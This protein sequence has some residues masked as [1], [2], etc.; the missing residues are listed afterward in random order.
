MNRSKTGEGILRREFRMEQAEFMG[1]GQG[2]KQLVRVM[3]VLLLLGVSFSSA[4]A[5]YIT[6]QIPVT[7][8]R[9]PGNEYK[10]L[11]SLTSPANIEILEENDNYFKVRAADGTEGYILKQYVTRQEPSAVVAARLQREQT[12]LRKK[13]ADL[14]Q[15][16]QD[17]QALQAENSTSLQQT[18]TELRKVQGDFDK[19]RQGAQN[20]T[21]TLAE[22]D[23]LQQENQ[24]QLQKIASLKK[25]NQYLWRNNIL[26]WFFAGVGVLCLGWLLGRRPPRRTRSF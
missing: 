24:E 26:R 11:K 22:R 19:L 1:R 21:E 12:A 20:I 14:K 7:L 6:D 2:C 23:R 5:A 25:E 8:R 9:G 4:W 16:N 10:I 18:E 17:L 3:I 13:V 15:Q